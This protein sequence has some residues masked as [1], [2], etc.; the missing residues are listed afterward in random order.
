MVLPHTRER[1]CS[2]SPG[3]LRYQRVLPS[4]WIICIIIKLIKVWYSTELARVRGLLDVRGVIFNVKPVARRLQVPEQTLTEI[5]KFWNDEDK[6]MEIVLEE[7]KKTTD[8]HNL[9]EI[10]ETLKHEGMLYFLQMDI[11]YIPLHQIPF[12]N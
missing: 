2:Y 7:W 5:E 8:D 11:F 12:L 4:A 10:L 9:S 6:Q 1:G 3:R